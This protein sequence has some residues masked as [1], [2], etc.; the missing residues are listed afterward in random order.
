MWQLS[1][2]LIAGLR[3]AGPYRTLLFATLGPVYPFHCF[4]QLADAA[5]SRAIDACAAMLE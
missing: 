3:I 2:N 4:T 1:C 5:Y